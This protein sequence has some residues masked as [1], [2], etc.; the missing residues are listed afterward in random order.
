[1]ISGAKTLH[2]ESFTVRTLLL[3]QFFSIWG[4]YSALSFDF[5]NSVIGAMLV[6]ALF[7]HIEK[8][9][10]KASALIF[11]LFLF[12]KEVMAIWGIFIL[13]GL[14]IKN[15]ASLSKQYIKLEIPLLITAVVYGSIVIFWAMPKLQLS[16]T[17]LQ[18]GRYAHIGNSVW[19]MI[20]NILRNP[21]I[22]FS[23]TRGDAI[24]DG[25]KAETIIMFLLAGG[26]FCILKPAYLIMV[27]PIFAQKFLSSDYG[28]WGINNHYSIEFVPILALATIDVVS[29]IKKAKFQNIIAITAVVLTIS[30]TFQTMESRQ[31]KWY[32][33]RNTQFYKKAHYQSDINRSEVFDIIEGIPSNATVST[34][35]ALAPRLAFRK[36]VF[37]FP[38]IKNADYI[39]LLKKEGT[40]PLSLDKLASEIEKLKVGNHYEAYF[41]SETLIALKK[42]L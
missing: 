30:S 14:M 7:Y 9:D 17:N 42:T 34:S 4:I 15:R 39:I 23:N 18:F 41:E 3:V 11:M 35:S 32:N 36:K 21:Q 5:H 38:N 20:T 8:R 24:Y 25:I 19:E 29:N 16:D 6:P 27:L 2:I 28:L 26:V 40:Y 22:I 33:G 37:L 12:T 31:S 10:I 13:I 1:M